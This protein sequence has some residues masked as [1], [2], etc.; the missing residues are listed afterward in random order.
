MRI[1]VFL[2]IVIIFKRIGFGFGWLVGWLVG[3][4]AC[5]CHVLSRI[6]EY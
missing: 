1:V 5:I 2:I 3:D 4:S 6:M